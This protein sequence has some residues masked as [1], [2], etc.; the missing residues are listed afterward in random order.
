MAGS[1]PGGFV[2]FARGTM[3]LRWRS[4]NVGGGGKRGAE[5]RVRAVALAAAT[6]LK[7]P[8]ASRHCRQ[9]GKRREAAPKVFAL[10]P[11]RDSTSRRRW[12]I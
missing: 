7:P 3:R 12:R 11:N 6:N 1:G 4:A 8:P 9:A 10:R 2:Y 5:P